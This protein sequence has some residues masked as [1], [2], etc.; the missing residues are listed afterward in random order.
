M[1]PPKLTVGE[2]TLAELA[3]HETFDLIKRKAAKNAVF[4]LNYI[5]FNRSSY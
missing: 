2:L 1:T 3:R 5:T 4:F